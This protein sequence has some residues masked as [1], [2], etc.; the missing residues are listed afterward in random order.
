[1][2]ELDAMPDDLVQTS[3]RM[4]KELLKDLKRIA[5]D[6]DKSLQD[7]IVEC[8]SDFVKKKSK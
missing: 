6:S 4:P 8:L 2:S 3:L 5:L 1:M 7:L